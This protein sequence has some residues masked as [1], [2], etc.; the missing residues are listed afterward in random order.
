MSYQHL[1]GAHTHGGNGSAVLDGLAQLA[2]VL[3]LAV[4]GLDVLMWLLHILIIIAATIGFTVLAA[5]GG[6]GWIK[7]RQFQ[8]HRYDRLMQAHEPYP[9]ALG[10]HVLPTRTVHATALPPGGD[11]HLH[12]PPGMTADQIAQ[13]LRRQRGQSW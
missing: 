13:L 6:Y 5:T 8:N 9:P 1:D 10:G 3:A 4:A 7:W 2:A 12:L 11:L